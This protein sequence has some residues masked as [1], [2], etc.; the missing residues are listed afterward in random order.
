MIHVD[1]ERIRHPEP[2]GAGHEQFEAQYR[3]A[4][5]DGHEIRVEAGKRAEFEVPAGNR[6]V[7]Y[8]LEGSVRLEG[9]DTPA[10]EGDVVWFRAAPIDEEE[11]VVGVEA[12]T[13]FRGVLVTRN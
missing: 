9:D 3:K 13:P 1:I 7:L 5:A 2:R 4:L 11:A 12:D 8:V 10:T 6:A